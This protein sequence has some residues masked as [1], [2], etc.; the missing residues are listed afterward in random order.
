MTFD[1]RTH[2]KPLARA[3][4]ELDLDAVRANTRAALDTGGVPLV[5][6]VKANAYGHGASWVARAAQEAGRPAEQNGQDHDT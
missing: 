6:V 1:G 2:A 4:V 5:A 3:W